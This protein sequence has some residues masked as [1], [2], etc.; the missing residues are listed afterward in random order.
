MS[1]LRQPAQ[2]PIPVERAV[3]WLPL[4]DA[5]YMLA[6]VLVAA[7]A[8]P[9]FVSREVLVSVEAHLRSG[10]EDDALGVLYGAN[11]FCSKTRIAYLLVEGAERAPTPSREHNRDAEMAAELRT[12]AHRV[13]ASGKLVIG[14]Y[15]GGADIT[16]RIGLREIG[17]H[18]AV[19]SEPWQV[20]LLRAGTAPDA[21]RRGA[22]ARVEPT[23]RR[24]Y[25]IPFVELLPRPSRNPTSRS[26]AV[27]WNNYRSEASVSVLPESE[28]QPTPASGP[29]A[30]RSRLSLLGALHGLIGSTPEEPEPSRAAIEHRV[31]TADIPARTTEPPVPGPQAPVQQAE[32][33]APEPEAPVQALEL[34]SQTGETAA[35]TAE[36]TPVSEPPVEAVA[37]SATPAEQDAT[38]P[39]TPVQATK[40]PAALA[41]DEALDEPRRLTRA[42]PFMPP[43]DTQRAP[44]PPP[45]R[46]VA[47][48]GSLTVPA[49]AAPPAHAPPSALPPFRQAPEMPV[50]ASAGAPAAWF[51][52]P[53]APPAP[54][55][56]RGVAAETEP[57]DAAP[58]LDTADTAETDDVPEPRA[59][60]DT[61][62]ET[63]TPVRTEAPGQPVERPVET[64]PLAMA[65]APAPVEAVEPDEPPPTPEPARPAASEPPRPETPGG[66]YPATLGV[67]TTLE[68][69]PADIARIFDASP[70]TGSERD[71]E[72]DLD[73]AGPP[74]PLAGYLRTLQRSRARTRLIAAA[75]VV[76]GLAGAVAL[77]ARQRTRDANAE[78]APAIPPVSS[79][80]TRARSGAAAPASKAHA[81]ASD[82]GAAAM[83]GYA[84]TRLA[85]ETTALAA[86][87]AS[88]GTALQVVLGP[89]PRTATDSLRHS[90][91]C[92]R[93]DS[94]R[95]D[96][97]MHGQAVQLARRYLTT[98]TDAPAVSRAAALVARADT[99]TTALRTPCPP[100]S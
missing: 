60:T 8:Q 90:L 78:T 17:L 25:P 31:P 11:Y 55:D 72:P 39:E 85:S 56:D 15:R 95:T 74:S 38:V 46:E 79:D 58:P 93:A 19:C 4:D 63:P 67:A 1:L 50:E 98:P 35:Q 44:A 14:W 57:P 40:Q 69:L 29:V 3:R 51:A 34:P 62:T 6:T 82:T 37:A 77:L 91:A 42:R 71:A 2:R 13:E 22:F 16:P 70:G 23:E 94:A 5:F 48:A 99:L 75:V 20:A 26:S 89:S 84:R 53:P 49:D 83:Q 24:V 9:L 33:A 97:I 43:T 68:E 54:T 47:I 87:V 81:D 28:L 27:T 32:P 73:D 80:T 100:E 61:P 30:G 10:A 36:P 65:D 18:L 12:L 41:E 86:D 64:P 52:P 88:L 7:K 92:A 66:R 21:P 96:A 45:E 76:L 59:L